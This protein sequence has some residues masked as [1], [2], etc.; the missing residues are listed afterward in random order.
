MQTIKEASTTTPAPYDYIVFTHKALPGAENVPKDLA[1]VVGDE[2]TIVIMQNGIGNEDAFRT[3]FP[4]NT[5]ITC[6]VRLL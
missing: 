5:M 1:L 6:S 4:G 3:E 2:T